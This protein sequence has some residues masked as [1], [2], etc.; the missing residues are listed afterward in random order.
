MM[1]IVR[2]LRKGKNDMGKFKEVAQCK[3]CGKI[4]QNGI[5]IFCYKCGSE[6]REELPTIPF[7]TSYFGLMVN[8]KAKGKLRLTDNCEKVIARRKMFRWEIKE[9][10]D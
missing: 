2:N 4:Y 8:E 3:K 6:L 1:I 7:P 5:P 10:Q 9:R